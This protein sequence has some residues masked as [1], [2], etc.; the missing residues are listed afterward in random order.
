MIRNQSATAIGHALAFNRSLRYLDLSFN[1]LGRDGG[2]AVGHA[3][4]DNPSLETLVLSYTGLE[5]QGASLACLETPPITSNSG[6][7]SSHPLA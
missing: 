1:K 6:T 4:I 7:S 5:A 2:L 3:L